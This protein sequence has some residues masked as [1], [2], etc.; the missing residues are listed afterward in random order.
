MPPSNLTQSLGTVT[1]WLA[2]PGAATLFN[3]A[4]QT[5][6]DRNRWPS[7]RGQRRRL[8]WMVS[9]ALL[10]GVSPQH[11]VPVS[12]SHSHGHAAL[13]LGPPGFQVGVDLEF[14]RHRDAMS[15]ARWAF[16]PRECA[17]IEALDES[18]RL[19]QFY[20]L[21]TLKEAFAKALK[22]DLQYALRECQIWR[23]TDG[24]RASAPASVPW[25]ADVFSP[26]DN[27]ML[28]VVRAAPDDTRISMG[29]VIQHQWPEGETPEWERV[30]G[31]QCS[32]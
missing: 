16:S 15:I 32:G 29:R 10:A 9:R 12:L 28:A 20:A 24:W 5:S 14:I 17:E 23:E 19:R 13:A 8:D 11:G 30:L 18:A 1:V 4:N 21:W 31:I 27:L 7:L 22:I 3:P 26:S 6:E 2:A 25:S